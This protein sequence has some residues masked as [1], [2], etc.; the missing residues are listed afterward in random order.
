M[1]QACRAPAGPPRSRGGEIRQTQ[2][3]LRVRVVPRLRGTRTDVELGAIQSSSDRC[4][5]RAHFSSVGRSFLTE[6]AKRRRAVDGDL[7]RLGEVDRRRAR[8][9]SVKS[10]TPRVFA[11][12]V[13]P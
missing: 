11:S 8:A 13:L 7:D 6:A 9:S 4:R 1:R 12:N 10:L 5:G 2:D 3:G